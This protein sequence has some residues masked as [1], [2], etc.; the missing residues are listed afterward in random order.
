[1]HL[2]QLHHNNDTLRVSS[3]HPLTV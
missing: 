3:A 2:T 1:V